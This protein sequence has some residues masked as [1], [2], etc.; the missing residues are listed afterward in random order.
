M[1]TMKQLLTR[2]LVAALTLSASAA[3]AGNVG[4]DLNFHLGGQPRPVVV[5]E[6]VYSPPAHEC[7]TDQDIQ[8]IF[9]WG[10]RSIGPP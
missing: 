4:V 1:T 6:Q 3:Y 9:Q 8:F 10:K 5:Q 2:H 7:R